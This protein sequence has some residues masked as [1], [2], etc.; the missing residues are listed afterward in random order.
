MWAEAHVLV[1]NSC[2]I[3]WSLLIP[4]LIWSDQIAALTFKL[5]MSQHCGRTSSRYRRAKV[6]KQIVRFCFLLTSQLDLSLQRSSRDPDRHPY[7]SHA[8][9]MS[10]VMTSAITNSVAWNKPR[11]LSR[12]W[13][14]WYVS[15]HLS[16][17][18]IT[19]GLGELSAWC[20]CC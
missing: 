7:L 3:I 9:A 8:P 18:S 17:D 12:G 4:A 6:D 11:L 5:Q 1:C 2:K 15:W 10:S 19:L 20:P 16:V 13:V 14:D